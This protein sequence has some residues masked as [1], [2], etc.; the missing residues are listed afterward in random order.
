MRLDIGKYII[1]KGKSFTQNIEYWI[2]YYSKGK[3]MICIDQAMPQE[4][5]NDE[6]QIFMHNDVTLIKVLKLSDP[7]IFERAKIMIEATDQFG[8]NKIFTAANL[9]AQERIFEKFPSLHK[10]L[11]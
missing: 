1:R 6:D 2:I 7:I 11:Q 10:T 9:S 4:V 8:H 5:L 3:K